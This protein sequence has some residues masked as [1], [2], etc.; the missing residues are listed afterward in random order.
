MFF[1]YKNSHRKFFNK[2]LVSNNRAV[3]YDS[4]RTVIYVR[5]SGRLPLRE[6]IR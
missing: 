3:V 6:A 1:V 2:R 5:G 4:R